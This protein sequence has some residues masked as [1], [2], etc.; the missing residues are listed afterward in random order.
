MKSIPIPFNAIVKPMS[1]VMKTKRLGKSDRHSYTK[2]CSG[3]CNLFTKNYMHVFSNLCIA[4]IMSIISENNILLV[5][6]RVEFC[7]KTLGG[8]NA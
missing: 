7:H 1:L 4:Y 6:H 8:I 3:Q 2:Y 5:Q